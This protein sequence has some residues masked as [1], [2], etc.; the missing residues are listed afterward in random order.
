MF[1]KITYTSFLSGIIYSTIILIM[2]LL[3]IKAQKRIFNRIEVR[4][5]L[6]CLGLVAFR[7]AMPIEV[8]SGPSIYLSDIYA[9]LC[10]A[11]RYKVISNFNVFEL[12]ICISLIGSIVLLI[13]RIAE[14]RKFVSFLN[15]CEL[16]DEIEVNISKKK[17]SILIFESDK[18]VEPFLTGL[19]YPKIVYPKY[20]KGDK[21]L[22]LLHEI[23]HYKNHDLYYKNLLE[24]L[25]VLFWWNPMV[26]ILRSEINN[27]LELRND[28]SVVSRITYPERVVYAETIVNCAKDKQ[29]KD[30][31]IGFSSSKNFLKTRVYSILTDTKDFRCLIIIVIVFLL[32][33][34][35]FFCVIEP[36]APPSLSTNEFLL[37]D[38]YALETDEGYTIYMNGNLIGELKKI[39]PEMS[40]IKIIKKE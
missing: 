36:S 3:Y 31:G 1:I 8:V 15:S 22:I 23:E 20:S 25:V 18:I 9:D 38:A 40:N 6:V 35:S 7:I 24:I 28:F 27:L 16:I 17:R 39:P 34:F 26:Y 12:L 10:R 21:K 29:A 4:M 19:T 14:Y 30:Y 5:I 2:L 32:T 33:I 13:K 37:D 11:L